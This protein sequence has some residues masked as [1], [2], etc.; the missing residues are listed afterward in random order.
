LKLIAF[1]VRDDE[2]ELFRQLSSEF[3]CEVKLVEDVLSFENVGLVKGFDGVSILG[4]SLLTTELQDK[5][6]ELGIPCCSTRTVGYNH[7]DVKHAHKIGL[8]L[9]NSDYP[10]TGVADY[11]IMLMLMVLRHYKQALWRGQVNDY[12]LHGLRG[13][14]MHDLTIG[15]VGTGRIGKAVISNLTG[16]GCK[17]LAY[18]VY[19]D[20][21]VAEKAQYVE[22][23]T[24]YKECDVIS[25]HTPLNDSTMYMIN[26]DS[27]ELM[28]DGVVLVNCAR[29]E[30]MD[31]E[32]LIWG[33]ESKKIG[34][35]ALDVIE[36]E[37]GI[38]HRDRRTDIL[39]NK[40][41]AYLRQFPNTVMTQHL[42][43]YTDI[44]V[45][46]MVRCAFEGIGSFLAGQPC[47][48]EI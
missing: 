35:L 27:L 26:R 2:K 36:G 9:C 29:G 23:E 45:A 38:Y 28:K 1:E 46:S 41:M 24:I 12:S 16:F 34:A 22:L 11:T 10:P 7:I 37:S 20:Q 17:L 47:R 19:Q 18:D 14:E 4:H 40:N 13:R 5:L 3:S 15:I 44:A 33:I 48:T 8:R 32:A 25:L 31:V 21:A 6:M 43:F 42:A 30:L 39:Q